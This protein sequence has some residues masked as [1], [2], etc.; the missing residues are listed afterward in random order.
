MGALRDREPERARR[1]VLGARGVGR[2]GRLSLRIF[3]TT[4]SYRPFKPIPTAHSNRPFKP[5]PTAHSYRPFKP[6]PTAHSNPFLPP[7]QT[8]SS[9]MG[10]RISFVLLLGSN[11]RDMFRS[12]FFS[13]CAFLSDVFFAALLV[14]PSLF[15]MSGC[16][17]STAFL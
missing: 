5:I 3:Q 8:H 9:G 1:D 17:F 12:Q 14:F 6:I 10:L 15:C 11:V 16:T 2:S 13:S 4:H 7:I